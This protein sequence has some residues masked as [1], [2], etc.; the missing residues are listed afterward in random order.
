LASDDNGDVIVTVDSEGGVS[1]ALAATVDNVV[2]FMKGMKLWY[3]DGNGTREILTFLDIDYIDDMHMV[4]LIWRSDDTELL[5]V[6]E[7]LN[8]IENPD[9][10]SI[11]QTNEEYY[12]ECHYLDPSDLEKIVHPQSLSPLREEIMSRFCLLHHTAFA[13]QG[14]I[15]KHLAQLRNHCPICVLCLFGT[16]HKSPWWTKSKTSHPI[17]KESNMSPGAKASTDQ[18]VSVQS[19]LI[20]HISGKLLI[21]MSMRL[22][23]LLFISLIMCMLISWEILHLMKWLL[24]S[25]VMII[26]LV[27]LALNQKDIM[28]IMVDLQIK[29]F[30]MIAW[31]TTNPSHF[32]E[33]VAI[34]RIALWKEKSKILCLVLEQYYFMPNKC[35]LI[36]PPLSFGLLHSNTL[37]IKWTNLFIVQMGKLLI[38]H[39]LVWILLSL[40]FQTSTPL[41]VLAMSWITAFNLAIQWFQKWEPQ[42]WMGLYVGHSPSHAA[43]IALILNPCTGHVSPQFHVV[44]D[45]D[46][47]TVPYLHSSQVPPFWADLVCASTKLHVYTKSQVDTWQSLPELTQKL[48]TSRVNRQRSQTLIWVLLQI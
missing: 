12:E 13:E 36:I 14:E 17:W 22:Q 30:G 48:V 46:F 29:D 7:M 37:K 19:G 33:L 21:S 41:V 2:S 1:F 24:P 11:C 16:A 9:I 32:V 40:M 39:L 43:N 3:N 47:T 20:P 4:C 6:P 5:V 15:P 26:I 10:A 23:Y 35:F 45:N 34:I 8:F 42:A 18:L 27:Y 38:K 31:T 25:M 28:L 44:F